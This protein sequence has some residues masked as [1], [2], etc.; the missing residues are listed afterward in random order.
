MYMHLKAGNSASATIHKQMGREKYAQ[1]LFV[2]KCELQS[3]IILLNHR[4]DGFV[5][6]GLVLERKGA[7]GRLLPGT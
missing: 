2:R 4:P 7:G 1:S 3:I 5:K 6:V